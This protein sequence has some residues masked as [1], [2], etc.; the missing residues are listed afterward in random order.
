M[1]KLF[2]I[3]ALVASS[4][5]LSAQVGIGT[6]T[7][8][9]ALDVV[10]SSSGFL[11]PRVANTAAVTTPINGMIVYDNSSNCIKGYQ[12]NAWSGCGFA[13]LG[14]GLV[15]PNQGTSEADAVTTS[16][17]VGT[18]TQQGTVPGVTAVEAAHKTGHTKNNDA[19]LFK[20]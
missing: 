12:N 15:A 2:L 20:K 3:F 14:S 17:V 18:G 6:T 5:S 9:G 1:K 13:N 8:Q 11:F 19:N 16:D 4:F 10:S 7:P